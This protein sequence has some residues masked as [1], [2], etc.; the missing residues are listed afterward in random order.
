MLFRSLAPEVHEELG[1]VYEG[2][3]LLNH[4]KIGQ[5]DV[6]DNMLSL[7]T[8]LRGQTALLSKGQ[9]NSNPSTLPIQELTKDMIDMLNEQIKRALGQL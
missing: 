2:L 9:A 8:A 5:S 4:A 1:V 3:L 6:P 7:L